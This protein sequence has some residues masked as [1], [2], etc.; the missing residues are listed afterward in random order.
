MN[1]DRYTKC[2]LTVI[3]ACLMWLCLMSSGSPL[4]AQPGSRT[5]ANANVQPVIL[6]GTGTLDQAGNVTVNFV[7]S[8]SRAGTDPTVPVSLP[9]TAARPLPVSLPYT[10]ASPRPAS[11][12]YSAA[13]PLSVE[14]ASVRKSGEWQPLRVS[15]EDAP[16]RRIPGNGSQ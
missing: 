10:A 4:A 6:V 9:F 12:A 7:Q 1:I 11:L 15:V 8:G 13:A 14:I 2:V 5:F 3:A 16:V